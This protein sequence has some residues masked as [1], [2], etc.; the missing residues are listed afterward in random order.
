MARPFRTLYGYAVTILAGIAIATCALGVAI[1]ERSRDAVD[2]VLDA[3]ASA[4]RTLFARIPRFITWEPAPRSMTPDHRASTSNVA[5]LDQH[6][7]AGH[8]VH[9][10]V[11][12]RSDHQRGVW[13]VA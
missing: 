6:R 2:M 7:R 11:R 5:Y 13:R 1:A 12:S 9:P 3:I 8:T 4:T 10:R